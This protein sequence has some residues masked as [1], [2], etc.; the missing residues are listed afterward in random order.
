[1]CDVDVG[2][3]VAK[4][5]YLLCWSEGITTYNNHFVLDM[6]RIGPR[7]VRPVG[8]RGGM[9]SLE[10]FR[11]STVGHLS[12]C[13]A[14]VRLLLTLGFAPDATWTCHLYQRLGH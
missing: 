4:R 12:S 10:H 11:L 1:M 2:P 7:K 6:I 8:G 5:M 14:L 9:L 13:W 3:I